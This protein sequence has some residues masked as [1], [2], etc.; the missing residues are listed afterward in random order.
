MKSARQIAAAKRAAR[1]LRKDPDHFAKLAAKRKGEKNPNM[2]RPVIP[3]ASAKGGSNRGNGEKEQQRR[4][5]SKELQ[6]KLEEETIKKADTETRPTKPIQ[7]KTKATEG[8]WNEE[9]TT[10]LG[11]WE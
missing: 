6:R 2:A 8:E 9:E 11:E 4:A 5:R 7:R 10:T 3:E 1:L